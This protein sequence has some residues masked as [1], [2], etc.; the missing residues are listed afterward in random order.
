MNYILELAIIVDMGKLFF[1]FLKNPVNK[2][3]DNKSKKVYTVHRNDSGRLDWQHLNP[4]S[5]FK[6]GA[7]FTFIT[8]SELVFYTV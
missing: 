6:S 4:L 1:I 2:C 3:R 7:I 5:N 8:I